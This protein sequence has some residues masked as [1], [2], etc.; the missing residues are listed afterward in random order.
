MHKIS[1]KNTFLSLRKMTPFNVLALLICILSIISV[2][3]LVFGAGLHPFSSSK[4]YISSS[5]NMEGSKDLKVSGTKY[6]VSSDYN[7]EQNYGSK[8]KEIKHETFSHLIIEFNQADYQWSLQPKTEN[9][10]PRIFVNFLPE[11]LADIFPIQKRKSL[12]IAAVLP[13]VLL[14][15]EEILKERNRLEDLVKGKWKFEELNENSKK[16]LVNLAMR[17]EVEKGNFQQLLERIDIIPPSL[18]IAQAAEES[19]W[20]T[21]RF[22]REGNSLFGLYTYDQ[23]SG[24]KPL[25][26]TK[27]Q[28]YY[29]QAYNSLIDTVR[30]YMHNLNFHFAYQE[31][32]EKRSL[33]RKNKGGLDSIQLLEYLTRYSLRGEQYITAIREIIL[34]N[35]LKKLDQSH[36]SL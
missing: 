8:Y 16:W 35:D 30:S 4:K 27:G 2:Y 28:K 17:Y 6:F 7:E 13:L 25:D 10:V 3:G 1:I 20:G 33:Q 24:M 18:A 36:L 9:N 34:S 22:A 5:D 21:S 31:F 29:I 12:F 14:A 15:N 23:E 32:R 11:D 26:R 19:G